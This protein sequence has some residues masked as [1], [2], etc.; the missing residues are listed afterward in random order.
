M[1]LEQM[2]F[3][4]RMRRELDQYLHPEKKTR[5][6]MPSPPAAKGYI[7][8]LAVRNRRLPINEIFSFTSSSISALEAE[9]EARKAARAAGWRIIAYRHDTIPIE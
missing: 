2:R 1:D 6:Q 5:R 3:E 9:I 7:I 8:Q 4:R